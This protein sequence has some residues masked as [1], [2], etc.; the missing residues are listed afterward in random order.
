MY[1]MYT[2]AAFRQKKKNEINQADWLVRWQVGVF[3]VPV[4]GKD[5][6]KRVETVLE[7]LHIRV[8][9]LHLHH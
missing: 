5:Y 2:F 9:S 8:F 6:L 3:I 1:P 4:V 7:D